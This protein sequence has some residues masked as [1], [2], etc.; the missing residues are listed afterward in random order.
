[1]FKTIAA[2]VMLSASLAFASGDLGTRGTGTGP[3]PKKAEKAPRESKKESAALGSTALG[4][5]ATPA[6]TTDKTAADTK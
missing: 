6:P 4:T 2:V 1:M 3:S 5:T